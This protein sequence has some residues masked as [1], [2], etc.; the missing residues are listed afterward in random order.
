[1]FVSE[2]HSS[3][4]GRRTPL[5]DQVEVQGLQANNTYV[6]AIAGDPLLAC[7]GTAV[8]ALDVDVGSMLE[9]LRGGTVFCRSSCLHPGAH[10]ETIQV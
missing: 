8:S 5:G 1:M 4:C 3:G 9:R 2:L 7:C 6:F 10:S